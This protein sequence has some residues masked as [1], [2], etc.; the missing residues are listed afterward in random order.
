MR[1]NHCL[2]RTLC[3]W[4]W[5][6]WRRDVGPV[7]GMPGQRILQALPCAAQLLLPVAHFAGRVMCERIPTCRLSVLPTVLIG[8]SCSLFVLKLSGRQE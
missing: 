5:E 4:Q 7:V 8:G 3:V 2:P 6:K 1:C